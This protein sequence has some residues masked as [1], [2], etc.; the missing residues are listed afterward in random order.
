MTTG[1]IL[2]SDGVNA[3]MPARSIQI[4][5]QTKIIAGREYYG[6]YSHKRKTIIWFRDYEIKWRN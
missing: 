6:S 4:F 5:T 1:K 2:V 3:G